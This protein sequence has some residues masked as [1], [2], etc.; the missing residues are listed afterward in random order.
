VHREAEIKRS[1]GSGSSALPPSFWNS[2]EALRDMVSAG[3][4]RGRDRDCQKQAPRDDASDE[5]YHDR[6]Q[7]K[8][9]HNREKTKDLPVVVERVQAKQGPPLGRR[10]ASMA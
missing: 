10:L 4:A 2:V 6:K 9:R 3:E 8:T 1:I 5:G 7:G